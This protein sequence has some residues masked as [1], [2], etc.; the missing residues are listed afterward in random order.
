LDV[1]N[2]NNNGGIHFSEHMA[3]VMMSAEENV[4]RLDPMLMRV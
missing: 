2:R 4:E 3:R 1:T